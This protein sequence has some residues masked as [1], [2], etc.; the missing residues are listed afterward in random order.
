MLPVVLGLLALSLSRVRKRGTAIILTTALTASWLASALSLRYCDRHRK[1][2]YRDAAQ[3]AKNALARGEVVWWSGD[4][5]AAVY[6]G[7]PMDGTHAGR[8]F[9]LNGAARTDLE[10]APLADLVAASKPD[11]YDASNELGT[12]IRDRGFVR[13]RNLQAFT[14]WRRPG[15]PG[16]PP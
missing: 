8:I 15:S 12:F 2:D 6:Y 13:E 4:K 7:L 10:L 9:L 5:A 1:D 3:I 14:I 16:A 11:I